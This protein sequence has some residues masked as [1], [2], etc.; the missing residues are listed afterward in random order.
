MRR[1]ETCPLPVL[2]CLRVAAHVHARSPRG[3]GDVQ[4]RAAIWFLYT[5]PSLRPPLSWNRHCCHLT[6]AHVIVGP[7]R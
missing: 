4:S 7:G 5:I 2:F 3:P 6:S 1:G